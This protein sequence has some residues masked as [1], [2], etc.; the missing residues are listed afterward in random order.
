MRNIACA[1]LLTLLLIGC[2]EEVT[3]QE[4]QR[5]AGQSSITRVIEHQGDVF[6]AEDTIPTPINDYS[7]TE[8]G[9][10]FTNKKRQ[11]FYT[12]LERL[13]TKE[14]VN[15]TFFIINQ[16]HTFLLD[17][18]EES[19]LVRYEAIDTRREEI[20]FVLS[21]QPERT[22]TTRYETIT[23]ENTLEDQLTLGKGT[24][25]VDGLSFP[26]TIGYKA[27]NPLAI[28]LNGD[29]TINGERALIHTK[30]GEEHEVKGVQ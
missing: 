2:T 5:P 1:L 21:T 19:F 16:G 11:T 23:Q 22:L 13:H 18:G 26:F 12:G 6:V 29:Y 17:K 14:S 3:T 20:T 8:D 30:S 25:V 9:L 27:G 7:L 28:D 10:S 4:I 15:D 24:L